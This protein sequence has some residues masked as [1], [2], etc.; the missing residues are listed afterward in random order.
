L[1]PLKD[2][3]PLITQVRSSHAEA[4]DQWSMQQEWLTL[5]LS[6]QVEEERESMFYIYTVTEKV[7]Q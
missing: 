2:L 3:S 7:T 5:Y 1:D 4:L 6:I